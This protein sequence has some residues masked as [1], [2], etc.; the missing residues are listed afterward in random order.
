MYKNKNVFCILYIVHLKMLQYQDTWLYVSGQERRVA[1]K[2]KLLFLIRCT[3]TTT[4]PIC[5]YVTGFTKTVPNCTFGNSRIT[6][7][8]H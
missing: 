5:T 4:E 8:K 6:N 7:L 1:H 3:S 2:G